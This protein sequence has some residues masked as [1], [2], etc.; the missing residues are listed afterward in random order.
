MQRL[1]MVLVLLV[2]L[3][4]K[5][6]SIFTLTMTW[7]YSQNPDRPASGFIV[8]RRLGSGEFELLAVLPL[9]QTYTDESARRGEN[10]YYVVAYDDL[11]ESTESNHLCRTFRRGKH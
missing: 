7:D 8:Y 9:E 11:E 2:C 1:W 3:A 10:C 5:P 4:A 6:V